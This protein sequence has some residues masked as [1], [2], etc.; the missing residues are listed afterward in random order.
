MKGQKPGKP[1]KNKPSEINTLDYRIESFIATLDIPLIVYDQSNTIRLVNAAFSRL[2]GYGSAELIGQKPPYSFQSL[3]GQSRLSPNSSWGQTIHRPIP[4]HTR[5]SAILWIIRRKLSLAKPEG[6]SGSLEIWSDVT[7]LIQ[8]QNDL[9]NALKNSD[10]KFKKLFDAVP[11]PLAINTFPDLVFVDVNRAF[12]KTSGFKRQDLIG[13]KTDSLPWTS[14]EQV[15]FIKNTIRQKGRVNKAEINLVSKTSQPHT[16]IFYA[17]GVKLGDQDYTLSASLDITERKEM[18]E[19]LKNSESFSSTLMKFSHNPIVVINPDSSIRY[20]NPALEELTGFSS[21]ELIGLKQPYP[22]W[23]PPSRKDYQRQNKLFSIYERRVVDRQCIDKSGRPFWISFTIVPIKEKNKILFYLANWVD[24]TQR[25]T[26]EIALRESEVFNSTLLAQAPNPMLVINK[27]ESIRYVNPAFEKL[28][29]YTQAELVGKHAPYPWWPDDKKSLYNQKNQ[30]NRHRGKAVDIREFRDKNG[31]HFWVEF[32]VIQVKEKKQVQFHFAIWQ[33]ITER[34]KAEDAVKEKEAYISSILQD[35]PDPL[36]VTDLEGRITYA[37]RALLQKTGYTSQE[38]IGCKEPYP[39]W[40]PPDYAKFDQQRIAGSNHDTFETERLYR[41][42]NG[43]EFWV[44]LHIRKVVVDGQIVHFLTN[45][46]DITERK[47]AEQALQE[48]EDFNNSL[49]ND[50][51]N[52]ILVTNADNSIRLA[53]RAFEKLT[54]FSSS[55]LVDR[56]LPY[57]WWPKI[58]AEDYT[59]A[60]LKGT[61]QE[62]F[63]YEKEGISKSGA[64]FWISVTVRWIK[65]NGQN[66]Y[67]IANCVDITEQTQTLKALRESEAFNSG[68][69]KDSPIPIL[70]TF[71]DLTIHYVNHSFE[72]LT[73]YSSSELIGLKVPF[74]WWPPEKVKAYSEEDSKTY[75]HEFHSYIRQGLHKD[76]H[77]FWMAVSARRIFEN[78]RMK[79]NIVNCIDITEVRM[80]EEALRSSEAFNSSLLSNA[81]NPILVANPDSSIRYVNPALEALTGYRLSEVKGMFP[82]YPWWVAD[83][84]AGQP[85]KQKPL[86]PGEELLGLERALKNKKGDIF[87][88]SLNLRKVEENGKVIYYVGNWT[89]ITERKKTEQL[90]QAELLRRRILIDQSSDGIVVLDSE[91]AVYEANLRFAEMLG[92][93]PEEIKQLHVWDWGVNRSREEL[94]ETLRQDDEKGHHFISRHC[95]KDN[96]IYDVEISTNAAQFG[97]QKLIFCVC[98]DITERKKMQ[99]ALQAE[100]L[101]R[102]ILIDQSSDGIVVL[103]RQGAVNEVNQ[104]F[105]EMLGYT[106]GELKSLHVWDWEYRLTQNQLVEMIGNVDEK[107]DHFE[108]QHRRKDGTIYDVEISTNGAVFGGQKLIF[109]VCRDITARK[110]SESALRES[111][112]FNASLQNDAPFP[113]IVV[114]A[115][116]SIKY[117]N[118]ALEKLTGYT[119]AEIIGLKPPYPWWQPNALPD[120]F[121]E[122]SALE[123]VE[124]KYREMLFHKKDGA[125]FWVAVSVRALRENGRIKYFLANWVDL[126]ARIKNET[127]LRE[128]EAFNASLL[129]NAPNPIMVNNQDSSVRYVNPAFEK[130]TGY[131]STEIAGKPVPYPWWPPDKVADYLE[132][133]EIGKALESNMM[134]RVMLNKQGQPFWAVESIHTVKENNQI[135]FFLANWV[136]ITDRKNT[137]EAIRESEAFNASLLNDAPNPVVVYNLDSTVKYANPAMLNL[138]GFS[139][140]EII[141]IKPPYPWWPPQNITQFINERQAHVDYD[142]DQMERRVIKKN[143]ESI[144]VSV[145]MRRVK[146]N[147]RTKYF[148]AN[149]LNITERKSMEERIIDLYQQEKAH[150]EELQEEARTRGLF[151]NVLAHELRTPVTPIMASTSMLID[152]YSDQ[153][154]DIKKKL[155]N[156]IYTGTRTLS[157]RLEELLDLARFSRGTFKLLVQPTDLKVFFNES[158]ALFASTIEQRQ[159]E[160][161]ARIADDLPVVEVDPS[162]LEQ[163]VL[164][165]L[166]NSSKF[167]PEKGRIDF[168]VSRKGLLLRV[169]VKDEGIGIAVEDQQR[170]FQPYHRVE[171]DRQQFTGLGLGLAISKQIIE[172]HGGKIWVES[173]LN[174]GSTFIFTIPLKVTH[175]PAVSQK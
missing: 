161:V 70:V 154:E 115:D 136:D 124:I 79:L 86:P 27:D 75:Q 152:L 121:R 67:A 94:L 95:R 48:K 129:N 142:T 3:S 106:T 148:L 18:E 125:V 55:E 59:R 40:R 34:K 51:P 76:G 112:A 171:Q 164:N 77:S 131:S 98:R 33:D 10:Y 175:S 99:D 9:A 160:L 91:G 35:A 109:C 173:V 68:L 137:E 22:W 147:G 133:D 89:D 138:V 50:A 170:L 58:K 120:I 88:I 21:A 42:K 26:A 73:G 41:H 155:V 172:A 169:E 168:T 12:L 111:E 30:Q 107:G 31:K 17:R 20:V 92:Y 39:W 156:N 130:L 102:R 14:R 49:I 74:P 46:F 114:N 47:K 126:T 7:S 87:W 96:S 119:A 113:I 140:S 1:G 163:V 6:F 166:S 174:Q 38:I 103:D 144:W 52:P 80:A 23:P 36:L 149:W 127:A 81:P 90:L 146:E 63:S 123:S 153:P 117:I 143:G 100:L 150:R 54:G 104:R 118:P 159:Q 116:R 56:G 8:K 64:P 45:W 122:T 82:P 4:V 29:G 78:G 28:T 128:S 60:W 135:K 132:Q 11:I 139:E 83:N 97:G 66:K 158:L 2:T 85:L 157:R 151:I 84:D 162:R 32:T 71:G 134:E 145:S 13:N 61:S 5:D 101:R 25:K 65:E 69:L 43:Q 19:A 15:A 105:A 72:T 167:S 44:T 141:G 110:H 24:I 93:T 108:T 62:L 53:N 16:A 57:P 37:N 165:L